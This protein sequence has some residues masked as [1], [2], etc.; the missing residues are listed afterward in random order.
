MYIGQ[1][2]P[3]QTRDTAD[4]PFDEKDIGLHTIKPVQLPITLL[5]SY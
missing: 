4:L 3:D 2:S 1:R 5:F